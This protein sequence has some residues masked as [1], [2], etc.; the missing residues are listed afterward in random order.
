ML[1]HDANEAADFSPKMNQ[2]S[3]ASGYAYTQFAIAGASPRQQLD[4]RFDRIAS[5][6]THRHHR[7]MQT[8]QIGVVNSAGANREN[9]ITVYA[10]IHA[11]QVRTGND[12]HLLD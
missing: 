8:C 6:A 11:S 2:Q 1:R 4:S 3:S 5:D 12:R 10:K 7:S 9:N